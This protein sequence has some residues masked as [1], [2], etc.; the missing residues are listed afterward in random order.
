M[1]AA[2]D[3]QLVLQALLTRFTDFDVADFERRALEVFGEPGAHLAAGS[4]QCDGGHECFLMN[5]LVKFRSN[6]EFGLM[7]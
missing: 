3:A 4:K 2:G 5:Q 7:V 1:L 6:P